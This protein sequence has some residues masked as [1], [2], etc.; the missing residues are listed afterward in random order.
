MWGVMEA[1]INFN[2]ITTLD[3]LKRVIVETW[4][5]IS[6]ET[7]DKIIG[8]LRKRLRNVI[9]EKGGPIHRDSIYRIIAL[10]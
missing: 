4:N 2:E 1:K 3:E 9:L 10:C 8:S 7:I 6:R 5:A